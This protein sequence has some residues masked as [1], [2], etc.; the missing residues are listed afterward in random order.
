MIFD[1]QMKKIGRFK[2]NTFLIK[3]HNITFQAGLF[4]SASFITIKN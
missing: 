2:K 3:Y 1:Y 4:N